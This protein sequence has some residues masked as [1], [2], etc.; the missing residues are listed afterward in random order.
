M[1]TQYIWEP[2]L[3]PAL[4]K[5]LAKPVHHSGGLIRNMDEFFF[6]GFSTGVYV[7]AHTC[8]QA[9]VFTCIWRPESNLR[10]HSSGAICLC[11]EISHWPGTHQVLRKLG[12]LA[13]RSASTFPSPRW[14]HPTLPLSNGGSRIE[15]KSSGLQG[16]HSINWPISSVPKQSF[17]KDSAN[18]PESKRLGQ[19]GQEFKHPPKIGYLKSITIGRNSQSIMLGL[20]PGYE[21]SMLSEEW[22]VCV[23]V[24]KGRWLRGHHCLKIRA[25]TT[26]GVTV[27]GTSTLFMNI[28][29]WVSAT[30]T[31]E[32]KLHSPSWWASN[33][34]GTY[35]WETKDVCSA[36]REAEL[37]DKETT[38]R[39]M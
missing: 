15:L 23:L 31:Y 27:P 18:C 9:C 1:S 13:C 26:P 35:G 8:R 20:K 24:H 12:C 22:R 25:V 17:Y 37:R 4:Q 7:G 3:T 33:V 21:W 30:H 10:C 5:E 29:W 39:E 38:G 6:E 2:W 32:K 16:K 36:D 14:P 34:D 11:F 19:M 28:E